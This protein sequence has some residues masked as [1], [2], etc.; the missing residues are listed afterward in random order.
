MLI[1]LANFEKESKSEETNME[2]ENEMDFRFKLLTSI[3]PKSVAGIMFMD[4]CG[5]SCFQESI[6]NPLIKV[7]P[8]NIRM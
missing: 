1:I 2:H 4:K 8:V 7:G 5:V 3:S 6:I